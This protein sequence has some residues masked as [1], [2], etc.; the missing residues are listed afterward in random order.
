[1]MATAN[2]RSPLLAAV[3][4]AASTL[5]AAPLPLAQAPPRR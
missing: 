2:L 3:L 4:L 5:L 1:M